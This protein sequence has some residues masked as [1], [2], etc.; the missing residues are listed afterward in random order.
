[1]SAEL[2]RRLLHDMGYS[3]QAPAKQNEGAA[4]PDRDGQF[5]YINEQAPVSTSAPTSRRSGSTRRSQHGL[6][7]HAGAM[8]C[9]SGL[10]G[11]VVVSLLVL[12]EPERSLA[13]DRRDPGL[14]L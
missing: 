5:R 10:P 3:L 11:V 6:A 13:R 4:H 8:K 9:W 2:V 7:G 14:S 12:V 1:M